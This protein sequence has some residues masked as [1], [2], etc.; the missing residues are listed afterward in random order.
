V[1]E[2][3]IH[4]PYFLDMWY[5]Y[6]L[7]CDEV[8]NL[9]DNSL[10]LLTDHDRLNSKMFFPFASYLKIRD[11]RTLQLSFQGRTNV[12]QGICLDVFPI[13]PLPY[14]VTNE[15]RD[16]L[17]IAKI[18]FLATAFPE[19][20][21]NSMKQKQP[22]GI[23]YDSLNTFLKLPYKQRG[24]NFDKYMADIYFQ[25]EH[26]GDIW[27]FARAAISKI[28]LN[29]YNFKIFRDVV[30]LPFE[31]TEVFA[32]IDYE[33][34]LST[35]YGENWRTPILTHIHSQTYSTDISYKE[36]FAKTT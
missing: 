26:M 35:F 16:K 27:R 22:L 19:V 13:D 11:S 36:Y 10:P 15:Q 31:K 3:E 17:E 14:N 21:K 12:N 2:K 29:Y 24:I 1:A 33:D 7:E 8:S 6:R 30:R 9:T 25:S 32:P 23:T 20:I 4:Y 18:L 34:A 5:N 28:E